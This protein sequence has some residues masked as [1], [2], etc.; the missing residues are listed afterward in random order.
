MKFVLGVFL[1]LLCISSPVLAIDTHG[2]SVFSNEYN[3]SP[4]QSPLTTTSSIRENGSTAVEKGQQHSTSVWSR[5]R[6]TDPPFNMFGLSGGSVDFLN[7]DRNNFSNISHND[8]DGQ[9][10]VLKKIYSVLRQKAYEIWNNYFNVKVGF[11]Y[12]YVLLV[13]GIIGYI[14]VRRR[15]NILNESPEGDGV[16]E[17]EKVKIS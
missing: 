5:Q 9:R 12:D 16:S 6:Y 7:N 11:T 4:Y 13:I 3:A 10:S 8:D 14:A 1:T 15:T 2:Q 17:N